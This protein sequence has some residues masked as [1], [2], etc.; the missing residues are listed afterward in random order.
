[1]HKNYFK[2]ILKANNYILFDECW[3]SNSSANI[4]RSSNSK[5]ASLNDRSVWDEVEVCLLMK[6]VLYVFIVF[7]LSSW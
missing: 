5:M 4:L 3:L 2:K 1:M 6:S 7:P